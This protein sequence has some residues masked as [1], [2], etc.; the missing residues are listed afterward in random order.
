MIDLN[1]AQLHIKYKRENEPEQQALHDV[2]LTLAYETPIGDIADNSIAKQ[3]VLDSN[4]A[5]LR[6]FSYL[7]TYV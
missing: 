7:E 6:V 2:G 3:N 4:H 5:I 1:I